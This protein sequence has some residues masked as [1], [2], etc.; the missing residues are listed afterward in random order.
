MHGR[1]PRVQLFPAMAAG[2]VATTKP[3]PMI[4]TVAAA[5]AILRVSVFNFP[6]LLGAEHTR[7]P[8]SAGSVRP[9]IEGLTVGLG[10]PSGNP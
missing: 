5:A 8:Q 7:Q 2:V 9:G 1:Y 3:D 4:A 10:F 6:P